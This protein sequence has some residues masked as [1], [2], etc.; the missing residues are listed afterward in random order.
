MRVTRLAWLTLAF[1]ILLSS[2][3]A[4]D[5]VVYSTDVNGVPIAFISKESSRSMTN[6]DLQNY[7]THL[8]N[9]GYTIYIINDSQVVDN[10]T[11]WKSVCN[12]VNTFFVMG[13]SD[14]A[15]SKWNNF[16]QNLNSCLSAHERFGVF[17]GGNVLTLIFDDGT[18]VSTIKA[19]YTF[20]NSTG[21]W[22]NLSFENGVYHFPEQYVYV[23]NSSQN[24]QGVYN[25]PGVIAY[26]EA[27][28][29]ENGDEP[30]RNHSLVMVKEELNYRVVFWGFNTSNLSCS[31]DCIG[32][33]LF[34]DLMEWL[35]DFDS[36]GFRISSDKSY[37]RPGET[38]RI[39]VSG[40]VNV[41]R[42]PIQG[43]VER[44]D[45]VNDS[46][47]F[48]VCD[49]SK[50]Y[51]SSYPLLST[52]PDGRYLIHVT[53]FPLSDTNH[54][55]VES[56]NVST[57]VSYNLTRGIFRVN[58][59]F[60]NGTPAV[61]CNVSLFFSSPNE[62]EE[63]ERM[64][65]EGY[66]VYYYSFELDETGEYGFEGNVS[67]Y[68]YIGHYAYKVNL[69]KLPNITFA[70]Q[71]MNVVMSVGSSDLICFNISNNED[72]NLT[73]VV[74]SLE[75]NGTNFTTLETNS[76][77]LTFNE[78]SRLCLNVTI[79]LDANKGNYTLNVLLENFSYRYPINIEVLKFGKLNVLTPNVELFVVESNSES[80]T[81][82]IR[83][84]G[85]D[86]LNI[87]NVYATGDISSLVSINVSKQQ[88]EP[89][90]VGKIEL[91]VSAPELSNE[92]LEE[93]YSGDLIIE[94]DSNETPSG[95]VLVSIHVVVDVTRTID[96]MRNKLSEIS[97]KLSKVEGEDIDVYIQEIT[98]LDEDL[99]EIY[100]KFSK[101]DYES[102]ISL[103]EMKREELASLESE[104]ESFVK[105]VEEKKTQSA[106]TTIL[107]FIGILFAIVVV[108]FFSFKMRKSEGYEWLYKKWGKIR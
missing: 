30:L 45:G 42:Y 25:Y 91:I 39:R 103:L 41:T 107:I 17:Y 35:T 13:V 65:E 44:P 5:L 24:P 97:E 67:C 31:S 88:L 7:F 80:T 63:V 46:L 60:L 96:E 68:G 22:V 87:T 100:D 51:C 34:D 36:L 2:V 104:V 93:I 95:Y 73:N 53:V 9:L 108:Y 11:T 12:I 81:I 83:N 28:L 102:S 70:P 4:E 69:T 99:N 77:N 71:E 56:L 79:P 105:E 98:K 94:T 38:V 62:T 55:W 78:P 82:L 84:D 21:K 50:S 32:W 16:T 58:V 106:I 6:L 54:F 72:R 59:T 66:G 64:D 49:D 48:S 8:A 57:N 47:S 37:Y 90:E 76:I 75:G 15:A 43:K 74:L 20:I 101:G 89:S 3:W 18:K 14:Y 23:L 40:R 19:N 27:D 10:T 86:V 92:T 26:T 85:G 52:D 33:R 29:D 1:L 61:H